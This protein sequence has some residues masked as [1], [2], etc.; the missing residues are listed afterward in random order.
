M[1]AG[2]FLSQADLDRSQTSR[3][4]ND[5]VLS[6]TNAGFNLQSAPAITGTFTNLPG[7]T[8]LY[9]NPLTT[10]QEFFRLSQ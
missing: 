9:T 3:L 4:D 8:S 5:L 7:A 10:P 1:D 2:E 6:W